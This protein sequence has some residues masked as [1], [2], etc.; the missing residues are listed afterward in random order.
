MLRE[1][2]FTLK[3]NRIAFGL[4]VAGL[5]VAFTV[6]TVIAFQI[7]YEFGYDRSY[8]Q[9]DRMFLIERYDKVFE[10]YQ[11]GI[12]TPL[13]ELIAA[14]VPEVEAYALVQQTD[15]K[16]FRIADGAD[17]SDFSACQSFVSPGFFGV[18][19]PE[20]IAGDPATCFGQPGSVALPLSLARKFFGED[21]PLGK[22]V[23]TGG[24]QSTVQLVYKDFPVNSTIRNAVLSPIEVNQWSEWSYMTY[25]IFRP[26]TDIGEVVRKMASLEIPN[27]TFKEL[28]KERMEYELTPVKDLYFY[29]KTVDLKKG[30]MNTT[31]SLIAI[32]LLTIV[33][34]YVNFINFSAALAPL[35]IRRINTQK[36]LGGTQ[37]RLRRNIIFEAG[38]LSL[39]G[40]GLSLLWTD[41]VLSSP[42]MYFF[43]AEKA[44]SAHLLLLAGGAV[45]ALV[46]GLLAGIYPAFYV[47]SFPPAMVLKGSFALTPKGKY[48]RNSLLSF[49]FIVTMVLLIAACFIKIQHNYMLNLE[50]GLN[51]ENVLY[52]PMSGEMR[53][54]AAA[55]VQELKTDPRILD[56]TLSG[57]I[58]GYVGSV[59]GRELDGKGIY[60]T[61][62]PV[63]HNFLRFFDIKLLEGTGFP[64]TMEAGADKIIVNR[65]FLRKY[66]LED[67]LGKKIGCYANEGTIVGVAED[68]HFNSVSEAITPMAFVYG[69][70]QYHRFTLIRVSGR[71]LSATIDHIRKTGERFSDRE[72]QVNFLDQA[73]ANLYQREENFA[74]LISVFGAVTV[75]IALMGIYG[76]I[77]FNSR[78]K[79]KEIGIRKVNG[80]TVGGLLVWLNKSFLGLLLLSFVVAV[81]LAWYIVRE[82][83]A[84]FAYRTPLYWWVFPAAGG[85]I[86]LITLLTISYQ[87]W[88]A[89]TINPVE[90]LKNE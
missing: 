33:V 79:L 39:L 78:F 6:L 36:V 45:F 60:F 80:A 82:W 49:Q 30:N 53:K 54:Q 50:T 88:K 35:R 75:L 63:D 8:R 89:A 70:D 32:A 2:L 10:N 87:S 62:W 69:D 17:G 14:S 61:S 43:T 74:R 52:V 90:T 4:N 81:P 1:F 26:G 34:A 84:G 16:I 29:G 22:V 7:V 65:E 86:L 67:I 51:K 37:A 55:F 72:C 15:E 20:I 58:P 44:L 38:I 23:E 28:L 25:L 71:E 48:F 5:S 85:L 42:L 24:K 68:I 31:L 73:M 66:G 27:P 57:N 76:L 56:C 11:Y 19:T 83:L 18:F 77:L 21:R 64:E 41:F 3:R 13:A 59:W 9:A 47:T 12:C 46:L 40:F